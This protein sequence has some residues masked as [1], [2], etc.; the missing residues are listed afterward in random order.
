MK[1][2]LLED[3]ADGDRSAA[4]IDADKRFSTRVICREPAILSGAAWFEE[5]FRQLGEV[6]IQWQK[7][8][9]ERLSAD[10]TVCTLEGNARV[11]L[12]GERTALNFIQMM[13]AAATAAEQYV[14]AVR[15]TGARIL[16]TRKTLPGLRHAQKYAVRC[17]G[18]CNHRM[19][20]YDAIMI[21]ENHIAAAGTIKAAVEN[22]RTLSPGLMLEVEVETLQQLDE[23]V[24]CGA[25][26][27]LLDNFS[28]EMLEQA[29]SRYS[30]KIELEASGG[31]NLDTVR[32]VAETGVDFISVGEMTKHVRAVDFSMRFN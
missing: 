24:A 30:G 23:T 16:D 13:S 29:V 32:S 27:V 10:K 22:A 15:G 26:R 20:L 25:D 6:R 14:K 18:A 12:S 3:I 2:A 7:T 31:I 4:L 21:K 19:G 11:I 9:G 8:D 1:S 5:T 17:G 28:I